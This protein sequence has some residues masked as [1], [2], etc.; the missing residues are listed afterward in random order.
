ML[1]MGSWADPLVEPE[2]FAEPFALPFPMPMP[3]AELI[4]ATDADVTEPEAECETEPG[5]CGAH[6]E[7]GESEE[8]VEGVVEME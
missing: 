6:S 8:R 4:P 7:R 3:D 2:P 5:V 1:E